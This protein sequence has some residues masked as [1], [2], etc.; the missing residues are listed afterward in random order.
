MVN[1]KK[2]INS[3][4]YASIGLSAI[5]TVAA[6]VTQQIA[7]IATPLTLS[8]TLSLIN[9]QKELGRATKRLTN[10]EQQSQAVRDSFNALPSAPTTIDFNNLQQGIIDDRKELKR[11]RTVILE[12]EKKD[13]DLSPFLTEI[14][15][16][17]DSIKQLGLNLSNF[18]KQ[19]SDSQDSIRVANTDLLLQ[20]VAGNLSNISADFLDIESLDSTSPL[21]DRSLN[22]KKVD[23][24]TIYSSIE[25]LKLKLQ[26]LEENSIVSEESIKQIGWRFLTLEKA[27]DD[28]QDPIEIANIQRSL[29]EI[30]NSV[31]EMSATATITKHEYI[32]DLAKLELAG[33]TIYVSIEQIES[34]IHLLTDNFSTIDIYDRLA[35]LDTSLSDLH[36]YN[37]SLNNKIERYDRY[38]IP[39]IVDAVISDKKID[40]L[41]QQQVDRSNLVQF[42]IVKQLL[43]K[44]HSYDL[45]SGRN[46]SRQIFLEALAQSQQRLILVCPWL[47]DYA[48][49]NDVRNLLI[50]ALSRG[51]S[52][53]IG[54]GHLSDV[55]N[56]IVPLSKQTLL[57]SKAKKW[58]GYS[59]V[60]WVYELQ[61]EYK[62]LLTLKILGTHEKFLVCD[63]KFAM[64]GSH[65][66]MTSG[67]SSNE[68]ELGVKTDSPETIDKL[69]ELFDR[70]GLQ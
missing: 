13:R 30:E 46:E 57:N 70:V 27:F 48:I 8:L 2:N 63:R 11:L 41:I 9:R 29:S 54:W 51:V 60:N 17:K 66:Y 20:E 32:L 55:K 68:R 4:E 49:D 62:N 15:L 7:Y 53:D 3:T 45:V 14:D 25:E 28:R 23:G 37:L 50:A 61:D 5:G 35:D 43:P 16:T 40:N 58:G 21:K 44:Q 47:T 59:A 18:Q 39:E 6:I 38:E 67:N 56:N 1:I 36:D 19:F 10:L 31:S 42:E 22:L 34:K 52:I 69:I 33:N 12:I 64:L 26:S 24:D 65:N